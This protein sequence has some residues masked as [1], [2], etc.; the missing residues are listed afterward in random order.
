MN[1][2]INLYKIKN[3]SYKLLTYVNIHDKIK[4]PSKSGTKF[5]E[6]AYD[7]YNRRSN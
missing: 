7:E 6:M 3:N 5:K 2:M 4:L 1:E